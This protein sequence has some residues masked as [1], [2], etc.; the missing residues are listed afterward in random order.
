MYL[1]ADHMF[2]EDPEESLQMVR[3]V[4]Q[5]FRC[6]P[7][8]YQ[9]QRERLAN[10][11][12][13]APWDFPSAMIFTRFNQFLAR[14]LQLEVGLY[15]FFFFCSLWTFPQSLSVFL[16]VQHIFTGFV[17]DYAG[18]SEDGKTGIWWT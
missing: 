14:M 18:H 10:H 2:R 13:H 17:W 7:D 15:S 16:N 12:K 4:L 3:T 8:S 11:V 9:T 1:S 6:F 5:V